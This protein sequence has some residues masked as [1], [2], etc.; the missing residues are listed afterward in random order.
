MDAAAR[1]SEL[2]EEF[3]SAAINDK[4]AVAAKITTSLTT[5]LA[6]DMSLE[7]RLRCVEL[8]NCCLDWQMGITRIPIDVEGELTPGMCIGN[9]L[10]LEV[11]QDGEKNRICRTIRVPMD[12]V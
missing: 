6:R 8:L 3:D 10:I 7:L 4:M 5:L 1:F 2:Q 9:A 12:S 11:L